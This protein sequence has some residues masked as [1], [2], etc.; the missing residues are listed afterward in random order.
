MIIYRYK[1]TDTLYLFWRIYYDK[2]V[3]LAIICELGKYASTPFEYLVIDSQWV[4]V[5]SY[6]NL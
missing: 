2:D 3:K 6:G 5:Y 1:A 4:E